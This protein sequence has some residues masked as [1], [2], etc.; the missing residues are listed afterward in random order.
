[1]QQTTKQ[2]RLL[3]RATPADRWSV[4]GAAFGARWASSPGEPATATC[5]PRPCT[6]ACRTCA[7]GSTRPWRPTEDGSPTEAC[8]RGSEQRVDVTRCR[9]DTHPVGGRLNRLRAKRS[10]VFIVIYA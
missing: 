5:A 2:Y 3:S 6:H 9:T 7:A 8:V 1:M 4:R 10:H